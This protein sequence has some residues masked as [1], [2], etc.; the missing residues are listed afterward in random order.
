MHDLVLITKKYTYII[1]SKYIFHN[2]EKDNDKVNTTLRIFLNI[3]F[4]VS[5]PNKKRKTTKIIV[6]G[7]DKTEG[8]KRTYRKTRRRETSFKAF[9]DFR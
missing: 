2:N 7:L 9:A 5:S 6:G 3:L 8:S 4:P 1:T